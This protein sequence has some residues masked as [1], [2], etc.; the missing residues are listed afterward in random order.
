[1]RTSQ[2][3]VPSQK[4]PLP[5]NAYFATQ[6]VANWEHAHALLEIFQPLTV[7]W[8]QN[9]S[10]LKRRMRATKRKHKLDPLRQ[11]FSH[12][13]KHFVVFARNYGLFRRI[14]FSSPSRRST[15]SSR[16]NGVA[17][18]R[19][20]KAKIPLALYFFFFTSGLTVNRLR[21]CFLLSDESVKNNPRGDVKGTVKRAARTQLGTKG[22]HQ[23]NRAA[24]LFS[25]CVCGWN[26][27]EF[28]RLDSHFSGLQRGSGR[29]PVTSWGLG[30]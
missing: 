3:V 26:V 1:M 9:A 12:H 2:N 16:N 11:Q 10:L 21:T 30:T 18:K 24:S 4:C 28:G 23:E 6:Y 22:D 29:R 25:T 20:R 17:T 5:V 19:E 13:P 15:D 14:L 7:W 8:Q 27:G